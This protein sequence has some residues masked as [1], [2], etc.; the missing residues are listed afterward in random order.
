M[1]WIVLAGSLGAVLALAG[2]AWALKL[3]AGPRIDD[4]ETARRLAR[5]A[6]S[7]F[8]PVDVTLDSEGRAALARGEDGAVVL[9]R[10]HGAQF[11]ARTFRVPPVVSRDGSRLKIASGERMFGNVTLDLGEAEAARWERLLSEHRA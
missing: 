4:E 8:E 1:S 9:L 10:A 2:I 5:D 7:G 3:G 6:H 11:A